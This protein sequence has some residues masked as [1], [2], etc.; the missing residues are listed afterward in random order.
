MALIGIGP[1]WQ[2]SAAVVDY[3][4]VSPLMRTM[5]RK[6]TPKRPRDTNQLAKMVV[7]LATMDAE[8]LAAARKAAATKPK[9]KAK[10]KAR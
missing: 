1:R 7:D 5:A 4:A 8:E 3:A 10:P 2:T 6:L 9:K